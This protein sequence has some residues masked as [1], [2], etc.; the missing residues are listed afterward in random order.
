MPLSDR[1][2]AALDEFKA[3]LVEEGVDEATVDAQTKFILPPV[4]T[5][6]GNYADLQ[7]MGAIAVTGTMPTPPDQ[8][9]LETSD[10]NEAFKAVDQVDP[11]AADGTVAADAGAQPAADGLDGMTKAELI[12]EAESRGVDVNSSMTKQELIDAMGGK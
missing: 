5:V 9:D 10:V 6:V 7:R 1:M 2:Q 3:A 8:D 4:E 12:A 11:V